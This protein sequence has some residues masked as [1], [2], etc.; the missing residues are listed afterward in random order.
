MQ[1]MF[2]AMLDFTTVVSYTTRITPWV[3]PNS[4]L[5]DSRHAALLVRVTYVDHYI[6]QFGRFLVCI[7]FIFYA[8]G[9]LSLVQLI[10][11]APTLS[12]ALALSFSLIPIGISSPSY[13]EGIVWSVILVVSSLMILYWSVIFVGFA[14]SAASDEITNWLQT[15]PK[16]NNSKPTDNDCMAPNDSIEPHIGKDIK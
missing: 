14:M 4:A 1:V 3:H 13:Y 10:D 15:L 6:P 16:D 11:N 9:Q 7:G 2:I 8:I 12:E 5:S